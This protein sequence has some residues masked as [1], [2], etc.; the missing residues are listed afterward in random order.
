M[1][2]QTSPITADVDLLLMGNPVGLSAAAK[3]LKFNIPLDT[4][5]SLEHELYDELSS[6]V[7]YPEV[8]N[9][10]IAI[11]EKGIKVSLCSNLALPYSVP[12]KL[13]LPFDPDFSA[14]SF[15]SRA[16]KP[17]REIY[18]LLCA[19]IN[20]FTFL[21]IFFSLYYY[22]LIVIICLIIIVQVLNVHLIKYYLLEI[23][24]KLIIMV[25]SNMECKLYTYQEVE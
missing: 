1:A 8:I 2:A 7:L 14:W 24:W 25:L 11:K 17:D 9:T 18:K 13:L 12:V 16:L 3:L 21:Y 15:N 23:Q 6:I 22:C 10:L 4:L 5:S 19:G 20:N